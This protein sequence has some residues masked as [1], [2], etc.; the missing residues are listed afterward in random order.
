MKQ[1]DKKNPWKNNL[2]LPGKIINGKKRTSIVSGCSGPRNA[3][4][5][6]ANPALGNLGLIDPDVEEIE[7]RVRSFL[8]G[9]NH[10]R[11]YYPRHDLLEATDTQAFSCQ[12]EITAS[13]ATR[14]CFASIF[15]VFF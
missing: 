12:D 1:R 15:I 14:F 2:I 3:S 4:T 7:C 6:P 8:S 10:L 5:S 13:L 9:N 11:D